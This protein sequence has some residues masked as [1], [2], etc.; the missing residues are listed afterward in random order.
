MKAKTHKAIHLKDYQEPS[1]WAKSVELDFNLCAGKTTVKSRVSYEKNQNG[2]G[3]QLTLNGR[4]LSL[5]E[6]SVNGKIL[7]DK[8]YSA[9]P[10]QFVLHN[11]ADAFTLELTTEIDPESN[12]ALEG[13]Y[14]SGE[15]YCTQCEPEGFRRITYYLDRPDVMSVFT[16]RIEAD[17]DTFPILLSNGN[18]KEK[19]DCENNRHFCV[20]HDPHPKPSYLFALVAGNLAKKET[21]YTTKSGR[22]VAIEIFVEEHNIDKCDFALTSVKNAMRW[23]ETVYGL[24][25]DLDV[26]M[27]VAVGDFNMGAMENK[28]LN[29]FN[30]KYVLADQATATDK[31]FKAVESVIGH[32]YFHNWT[33]N[34]VTCRDWF[35]LSLKEGLTV[36]RDQEFSSDMGS[37]GIVRIQEVNALRN[38]QFI[39]D[40]GPMAHPVRPDSYIE[41]NNF[42]TATV[43]N[44]GAEVIRMIHTLIGPTNYHK[45]MDLFFERFDGKAVTIEDFVQ[46]MQ[47]AS[48]YDFDQFK[49]W[50]FQAGTPSIDVNQSYDAK[51]KSLK[52]TFKQSIPDT[53][54]Q[55]NKL[56]QVIP[57]KAKFF[58]SK[59]GKAIPLTYNGKTAEE[60]VIVIDSTEQVLKFDKVSAQPIPSLLRDFSAPVI[61]NYSYND[62]ELRF[63][64]KHDDNAFVRYEA[65]QDLWIMILKDRI[66]KQMDTIS[67]ADINSFKV[68][69][70]DKDLDKQLIAKA[71]IPP[72]VEFLTNRIKDLNLDDLFQARLWLI[73]A[74]SIQLEKELNDA[75][76]NCCNQHD[77]QF[78]PEAISDRD[79]KMTCLQLLTASGKQDYIDLATK[80]YE[81]SN[82]MTESIGALQALVSIDCKE[83]ETL[84]KSYYDSW[85]HDDLVLDKWFASQA[86]SNHPKVLSHV[87]ELSKHAKFNLLQP[88]RVYA[89]LRSF[90]KCNPFGFHNQNGEGYKLLADFV[91]TIDTKNPS[92]ASLLAT[93][94]SQWKSFDEKRQ[95]LM[96]AQL[97]R[98]AACENLSKDTY[99]VVT[100]SLGKDS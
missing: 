85:N 35:Q 62:E 82:N 25:Y 45:G 57:V 18:L 24:E 36:F 37:R 74:I 40:S 5:L 28:G 97:E 19:G 96:K 23:D 49:R 51:D 73:E 63:L 75:Y 95:A 6:A 76:H 89:L 27:I 12:T 38:S 86:S 32:E 22:K 81:T 84:L 7:S 65:A 91:L 46:A 98:L 69:V 47:D 16:T 52:I 77:D 50:Y 39:E 56:A 4:G 17:K 66:K 10:E 53:P 67:D 48:G 80:V 3:D 72:T 26:F 9:T 55:S 8:D 43:Y 93:S 78:S 79:L 90:V 11:S 71:L 59:S 88:N 99:E 33:G 58:D 42:Y 29:I 87:K 61:L 20:W 13:L 41:I 92:V 21:S 70:S 94:L 15:K 31:D 1:Y 30:S 44:K 2:P 60:H 34:R 64:I 68:L 14:K 83:R 100:K 54:Q